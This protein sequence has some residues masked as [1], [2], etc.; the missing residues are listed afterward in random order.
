M[1]KDS[2]SYPLRIRELQIFAAFR[3]KLMIDRLVETDRGGT[4]KT[5]ARARA[6]KKPVV[7]QDFETSKKAWGF[8]RDIEVPARPCALQPTDK[9]GDWP[10]G[11][12]AGSLTF[13]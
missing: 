9:R 2:R 7:H 3:D 6:S 4:R 8:N 10:V 11:T 5:R 1:I 13:F 12:G